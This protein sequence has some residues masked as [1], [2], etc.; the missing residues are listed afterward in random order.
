MDINYSLEEKDSQNILTKNTEPSTTKLPEIRIVAKNQD[1]HKESFHNLL[2][3]YANSTSTKPIS[4]FSDKN[5]RSSKGLHGFDIGSVSK[6]RSKSPLQI[7]F[8]ATTEAEEKQANENKKRMRDIVPDLIAAM[9][10]NAWEPLDKK[11]PYEVPRLKHIDWPAIIK[12]SN[13][14]LRC[15]K[16]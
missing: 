14:L 9:L 2:N 16:C 5:Y 1:F 6:R 11:D 3:L 15:K 7:S 12:K 13:N 8:T 10:A 4:L